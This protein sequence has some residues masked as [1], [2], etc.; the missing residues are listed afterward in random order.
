MIPLI[1]EHRAELDRLCREFSVRRLDVFG[2]AASGPFASATSDIDFI[3]TFADTAGGG[4]ADRY[5]GFA[6]ALERLFQR[7]V[8]LLTERSIRNPIFRQ[9]VEAGRKLVY[10]ERSQ[11]AAA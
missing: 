11:E 4:Y 3:V 1:E 8:D 2:S 5:L 9:A 6:E 7:K 10:E